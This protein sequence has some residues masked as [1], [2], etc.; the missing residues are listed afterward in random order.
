MIFRLVS[1]VRQNSSLIQIEILKNENYYVKST[2][3]NKKMR[4]NMKRNP[5]VIES[6]L[7]N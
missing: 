7:E 5:R 2:A 6:S 1:S 4:M 3:A